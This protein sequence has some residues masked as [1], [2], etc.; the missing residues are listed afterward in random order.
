MLAITT[1]TPDIAK[2]VFR[3]RCRCAY[4]G[5]SIE[6]KP[7]ALLGTGSRCERWLTRGSPFRSRHLLLFG[8]A[9]R[10]RL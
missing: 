1:I 9:G 3:S 8:H 4:P 5:Q 2:S 6:V 10:S 7:G